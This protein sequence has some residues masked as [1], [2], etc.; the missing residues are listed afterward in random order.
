MNYNGTPMTADVA[1]EGMEQPVVHWTPSIAVCGLD[2][3]VGDRFPGWRGDLL[4]GALQQQELRRVVLDGD[5]VKEQEVLFRGIGRVRSVHTGP[6][7]FV[8]VCLENPG[9]VV[10]LVPAK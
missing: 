6:D 3:Y 10:R 1:R 9:R 2:F 5:T 4:V 7:G 8:Y